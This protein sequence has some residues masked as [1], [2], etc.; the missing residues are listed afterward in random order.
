MF[1]CVRQLYSNHAVKKV[2]SFIFK[3][4]YNVTI[5]L[6]KTMTETVSSKISLLRSRISFL[7]LILAP[8]R[9][10]VTQLL[11]TRSTYRACFLCSYFAACGFSSRC[12]NDKLSGSVREER[13]SWAGRGLQVCS[14]VLDPSR[15]RWCHTPDGPGRLR[16]ADSRRRQPGSSCSH[17]TG[18]MNITL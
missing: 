1:L 17:I 5:V 10:Q 15:P 16:W 14:W 11:L 8:N 12:G 3:F 9:S 4:F 7:R 13:W 18:L 2:D 6:F